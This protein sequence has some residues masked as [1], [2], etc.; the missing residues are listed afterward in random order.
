MLFRS[1]TDK[2]KEQIAFSNVYVQN[3]QIII[4]NSKSKIVSKS[5]LSDKTVGLQ[6]GSSSETALAKDTTLSKSVKEVKK[7]S[8]NTEALLDLKAGRIDA[9]M[10]DEVVGRYYVSKKP[11]SYKVLDGNLGVEDYGVGIR[12]NDVTLTAEINKQLGEIKKDGTANTI[13]KKWFGKDI[14]YK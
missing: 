14:I 5:A 11:G 4:V 13:S 10:V 6:L 2:R 7:Y 1:I 8:N 9:V 12:K 3:K